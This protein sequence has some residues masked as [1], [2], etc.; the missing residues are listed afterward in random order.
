MILCHWKALEIKKGGSQGPG[1]MYTRGGDHSGA[2]RVQNGGGGGSNG[3]EKM[4]M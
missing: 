3:W 2:Y 4:C 1:C